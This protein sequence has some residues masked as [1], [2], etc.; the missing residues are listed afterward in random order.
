MDESSNKTK[1]RFSF[2]EEDSNADA[3][4]GR[5]NSLKAILAASGSVAAVKAGEDSWSK[6]LV[7]S[8]VVPAHAFCTCTV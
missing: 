7:D 2:S 3:A 6:P 5:R 4:R 8:V 1:D